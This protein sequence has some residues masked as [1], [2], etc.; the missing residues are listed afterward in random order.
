MEV[1]MTQA[2]AR[3]LLQSY[4]IEIEKRLAVYGWRSQRIPEAMEDAR[5]MYGR[6]PLDGSKEKAMR[7]LGYMQ[8][9]LVT[10]K[11]FTLAQVKEHSK[12]GRVR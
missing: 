4:C 9:V 5:R 10:S 6:F 1:E 11:V 7:W 8:G 12:N 2:E 3:R